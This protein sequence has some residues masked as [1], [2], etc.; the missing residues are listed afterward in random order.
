[1]GQDRA[2]DEGF[3]IV[4]EKGRYNTQREADDKE[5]AGTGQSSGRVLL[6][7]TELLSTKYAPA[8]E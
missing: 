2:F 7:I 5:E 6:P 3:G 1:M 8:A 4:H